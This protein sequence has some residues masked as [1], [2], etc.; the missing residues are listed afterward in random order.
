MRKMIQI[1]ILKIDVLH[2]RKADITHMEILSRPT[3]FFFSIKSDSTFDIFFLPICEDDI[4]VYYRSILAMISEWS[5]FYLSLCQ[6]IRYKLPKERTNMRKNNNHLFF[7]NGGVRWKIINQGF[8]STW[9]IDLFIFMYNLP[10][11]QICFRIFSHF[12]LALVS[13]TFHSGFCKTMKYL[14]F[15]LIFFLSG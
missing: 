5:V 1:N 10:I 11:Y 6:G 13:W 8:F 4:E 14:L 15:D 3:P 12:V 9:H 7:V 2:F